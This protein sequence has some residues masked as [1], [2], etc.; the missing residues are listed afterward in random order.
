MKNILLTNKFRLQIFLFIL[1]LGVI[2]GFIY[3][4]ITKDNWYSNIFLACE[5]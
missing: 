1:V 4:K 5:I 3:S 2:S